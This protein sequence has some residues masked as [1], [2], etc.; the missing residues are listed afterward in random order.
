MVSTDESARDPHPLEA[1]LGHRFRDPELIERALT[2]RSAVRGANPSYERLEFLGDRVLA[3]VV[4]DMLMRRFPTEPEGALSK[5]LNA[6]VR[7]ETLAEIAKEIGLSDHIRAAPTDAET[8]PVSESAAVLADVVEALIA[9]IYRDAGLAAA[10]AFIE[11]YWRPRLTATKAP[12]KDAK[13]ALQEWAMARGLPLPAYETVEASGPD[14]AP[15][16]VISVS[17]EGEPPEQASGGTKRSASQAAAERL[18]G[19]LETTSP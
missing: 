14:H 4:S 8:G 17:V 10:E 7:R 13:S 12:P 9:A 3:L 15:V 16:F 2:H 11:T 1:A 18:L 19:R 5:R 6:L